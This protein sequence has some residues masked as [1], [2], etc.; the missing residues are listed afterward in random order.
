[1]SMPDVTGS[2]AQDGAPTGQSDDAIQRLLADAEL[3]PDRQQSYHLIN[4]EREAR[5]APDL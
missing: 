5:K 3:L 1:M 2:S 4:A